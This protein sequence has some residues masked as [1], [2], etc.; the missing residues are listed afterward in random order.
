MDKCV[1]I[2]NSLPESERDYNAL[3]TICENIMTSR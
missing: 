1:K 2:Y 3:L